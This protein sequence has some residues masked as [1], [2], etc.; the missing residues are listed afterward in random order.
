MVLFST[1]SWLL[2]LL[3]GRLYP[4][5]KSYKAIESRN[6]N[7]LYS[8]LIYWVIHALFSSCETLADILVFWIPFYPEMKLLFLLW[9]VLPQ[10]RGALYLYDYHLQP[11]MRLHYESEIDRVILKFHAIAKQKAIAH[12]RHL[13]AWAHDM[14]LYMVFSVQDKFMHGNNA[15]TTSIPPNNIHSVRPIA[16]TR[17]STRAIPANR[18]QELSDT[19]SEGVIMDNQDDEPDCYILEPAQPSSSHRRTYHDEDET[20]MVPHRR[21]NANN[22]GRIGNA[23]AR[24]PSSS[25][26]YTSTSLHSQRSQQVVTYPPPSSAHPY[27]PMHA[28]APHESNTHYQSTR[29]HDEANKLRGERH[30]LSQLMKNLDDQERLTRFTSAGS[31]SSSNGSGNGRYAPQPPSSPMVEDAPIVTNSARTRYRTT[32]TRN[33]ASIRNASPCRPNEPPSPIGGSTSARERAKHNISRPG[34]FG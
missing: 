27:E 2:S 23:R 26:H 32:K 34:P 7:D 24:Q 14:L 22:I 33:G 25:S 19:D 3:F 9:L 13:M 21:N 10:T 18:I 1:A 4:A 17:Q 5:Y 16:T 8:W 29:D 28:R 30:R 12:G 11:Q 15:T 20:Q 31:S 6:V